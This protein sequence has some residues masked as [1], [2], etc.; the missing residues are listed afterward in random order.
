MWKIYP[1]EQSLAATDLAH[2]Q[3]CRNAGPA[4]YPVLLQWSP[5]QISEI[6]R[7]FL[8]SQ[9]FPSITAGTGGRWRCVSTIPTSPVNFQRLVSEPRPKKRRK[10]PIF[11]R[12]TVAPLCRASDANHYGSMRSPFRGAALVT[13]GP[14]PPN[15]RFLPKGGVKLSGR[16]DGR[17]PP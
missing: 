8:R 7:K 16:T 5:G 14:T 13:S 2:G 9:I 4:K 3:H 17:T 12:C 6:R 11:P 1:K 15:A 10:T